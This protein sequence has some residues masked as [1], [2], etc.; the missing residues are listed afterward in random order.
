MFENVEV[1]QIQFMDRVVDFSTVLQRRVPT[2]QTVQKTD[3]IPQLQF[4][5]K[6]YDTRCCITT[7]A[8]VTEQKTVDVPQLHCTDKVVDDLAVAVAV[9]CQRGR[10]FSCSSSTG[11]RPWCSCSDVFAVLD[12]VVDCPLRPTT[13]ALG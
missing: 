9:P 5:D 12:I 8:R 11:G 2:V 10:C 3:E 1:P 4:L 7:G 6:V 13:G